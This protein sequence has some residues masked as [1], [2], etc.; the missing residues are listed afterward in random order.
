[1][2]KTIHIIHHSHTDFGYTDLPSTIWAL[3]VDFIRQA[4]RFAEQTAGYSEEAR[5]RWT[6]EAA[7][8]VDEFLRTATAEERARFGKLVDAGQ[9]EVAAMPC[10][11][12]SPITA[13]QWQATMR[14]LE[15]IYKAYCPVTALQ[16]D[17][18]GVPWGVIPS[19]RA[20]GVKYFWMGLNGYSGGAPRPVPSLWW[21]QG[22]TDAKLLT[23]LGYGYGD[24]YGFF[25]H[26]SWRHGPVPASHDVWFNKPEREEIFDAS[27]DALKQAHGILRES[28][29]GR[30][31]NYPYETLAVQTT[32]M[33][34]IDND[35]PCRQLSEFVRAWNEAGLQPLLRLSTPRVFMEEME[36]QNGAK[37]E[38][39]R[40]DWCDWWSDGV[41]STPSALATNQQAKQ[42]L[43]DL[44]RA[45]ELLQSDLA[46][47]QQLLSDTWRSVQLFDEHTWGAY[48]SV[49]RP[50]AS[51]TV[52]N[53]GQK[54]N[55]AYQAE[56]D[57]RRLQAEIIRSSR[58]YK[59]FSSTRV[60][61]V[62]NPGTETRS[63][64]VEISA[65]AMRFAANAAQDLE[66]GQIYPLENLFGPEW[67]GPS[68]QTPKPPPFDV[69]NDA[70]PFH[71]VKSRFFLADLAAG[72]RRRFKL[73]Q[74]RQE[75]PAIHQAASQNRFFRWQWDADRGRLLQ[76]TGL[77]GDA[78]LLDKGE[79]Y[80]LGE[81]LAE[82]PKDK[83]TR[84]ALAGRNPQTLAGQIALERPRLMEWK[85]EP[86]HYGAGYRV[87]WEH[88]SC[89]RIEQRW[90]FFNDCPRLE[91]TTTLW[92]KEYA[93]PQALY[94]ALPFGLRDPEASYESV[95]YKTR[96]GHDQMPQCCGEYVL[97]GEGVVFAGKGLSLAVNC[98]QT[99]LVS[100]ERLQTR[101]GQRAFAPRNAH[102]YCTLSQNYWSTNFAITKADKLVVRHV[103]QASSEPDRLLAAT[104]SLLWA[105]PS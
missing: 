31:R 85:A 33:W 46:P 52:G 80:A 88:D 48:D 39:V 102:L 81:I 77:E 59:P 13:A 60:L 30:A 49:A 19:L 90:D 1:M 40:G 97:V 87:A 14:R 22:P 32:N 64:W 17:I 79:E 8:V 84:D 21:W 20:A 42:L 38:T 34:R 12:T 26:G 76:W 96:A 83:A 63:G 73:I 45:A 61:T 56:E 24:G 74:V 3:Q 25:H 5:F 86:A 51:R 7:L 67:D 69:P 27:K 66:S 44:P 99:P 68:P 16:N 62:L 82:R 4:M 6:C 57:A 9:I 10:N 36:K 18:N 23:W 53:Y 35:P 11:L 41:T 70:W 15:P 28:L 94:L 58:S 105:F 104:R 98:S 95:G 71:I 100:F 29:A 47:H 43:A 75:P 103:I 78:P 101:N 37:A 65:R 2:I 89:H 91:L 55:L 93:Q 72:A 50:Y 54:I 92:L